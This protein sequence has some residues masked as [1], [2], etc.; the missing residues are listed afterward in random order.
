MFKTGAVNF[1]VPPATPFQSTSI[2]A[3]KGLQYSDNPL[4]V[5][6]ESASDM[7]NVYLNE[8]GTLTTRPRLEYEKSY[9]D[10]EIIVWMY[11]CKDGS[12]KYVKEK[13]SIK[14][15]KIINRIILNDEET[16]YQV[17][18]SSTDSSYLSDKIAIIIE[19]NNDL[20]V[21]DNSEIY[22]DVTQNPIT[23]K[24]K[25]K[26]DINENKISSFKKNN[27]IFVL[28]GDSYLYIKSIENEYDYILYDVFLNDDVYI[29][30]IKIDDKLSLETNNILTD[31]YYEKF[32]W[33]N[34]ED[35]SK[36]VNRDNVVKIIN[37]YFKAGEFKEA[38]KI[39]PILEDG[40]YSQEFFPLNDGGF[41]AIYLLNEKSAY[42]VNK[43][44]LMVCNLKNGEY[45]NKSYKI[46][47]HVLGI[48]NNG[49]YICYSQQQTDQDSI[50]IVRN[51]ETKEEKILKL[52]DGSTD[53][54]IS[55]KLS[56]FGNFIISD[57][58]YLVFGAYYDDSSAFVASCFFK[59]SNG[60]YVYKTDS[61]FTNITENFTRFFNYNGTDIRI[62]L[63]ETLDKYL[64]EMT[65]NEKN[66][67][68]IVKTNV[69][70]ELIQDPNKY[71][72]DSHSPNLKYYNRFTEIGSRPGDIGF[73]PGEPIQYLVE[74]FDENYTKIKDVNISLKY[75]PS[76]DYSIDYSIDDLGNSFFY[77]TNSYSEESSKLYQITKEGSSFPVL[78]TDIEYKHLN[79][80]KLNLCKIILN[81]DDN[82]NV[83][84][85]A[86]YSS[87]YSSIEPKFKI[88]LK[89]ENYEF[90]D[91]KI[92]NY[93]RF[94]NNYWFY[95][96]SNKIYYTSFND[97]TYIGEFNYINIGDDSRI[98]GFNIL[99]DNLILCYKKD[100]LYL[101]TREEISDKEQAYIVTETRSTNGNIPVGQTIITRYTELPL[102]ID[103]N[104]V[105]TISQV[106]NVSLS[107]HVTTSLSR[108]MDK[109]FL[110][111]PNKETILTH[112]H[113]YWTYLIFPG[114]PAK[115][116]VLDNRTNE[117][118]Y[119]ELPDGDIVSLWEITETVEDELFTITKY[120]TSTGRVYALR[121]N[122]KVTQI[123]ALNS[124]DFYTSYEDDLYHGEQEIE[125]SWTSQILPLTFSKYSKE[126]PALGYSKQLVQ[127]GFLFTDT[128]E[129][130]EFSLK[131]SFKVFRKNMSEVDEKSVFGT[132][133]RVRSIL[134][135]TYIPRI[136]FLQIKLENSELDTNHQTNSPNANNKLNLLQLKF[137]YKLMEERS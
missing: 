33:N 87:F 29:P 52:P 31:K 32:Y 42:D 49:K 108:L 81:S 63:E 91:F 58:G 102:N 54:L 90:P 2:S 82:P 115:I 19:K 132:L 78:E 111:E 106:K 34:R 124:S 88:L 12:S 119:W 117:W 118:Y 15:E 53:L 67:L 39:S 133:N 48:S 69:T 97:P 85:E 5:D 112:N 41:A 107:E 114:Y 10:R 109:K 103:D 121:I 20:F 120:I 62:L 16:L 38:M 125:W 113:R 7:L 9:C 73:I 110:A 25:V 3:F 137:K 122:D 24:L 66:D 30:T 136:S 101:I 28:N 116:Y 65:L 89:D 94:Q 131:Y 44:L 61:L 84:L 50:L 26:F 36:Y 80:Y 8:S 17:K 35:L 18:V 123:D 22:V 43:N 134:K 21:V 72:Y 46:D 27:F 6:S 93:I 55:K 83:F 11:V 13:R 64:V 135:R 127:T 71:K 68:V 59:K 86:S 40:T 37:E 129:T 14:L 74:I 51:L 92:D 75:D 4:N 60:E 47:G 100:S 126:Y 128:D 105:F 104:G 1:N 99:S 130:D 76:A 79:P 77:Y 98:T 56:D 57:N 95:G 23:L 70:T 45:I 96:N